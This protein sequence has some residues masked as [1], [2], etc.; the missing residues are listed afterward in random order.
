[1]EQKP[2]PLGLVST[3]SK[4][5]PVLNWIYVDTNTLE[6]RYGNKTQSLPHIYAPWDWTEGQE[7]LTLD[8]WEGFVALEEEVGSGNWILGYD[9]DD[10]LLRNVRGDRTVLECS[11]RRQL[12]N[13]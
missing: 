10:D 2:Q 8:G 6:L 7:A 5:P 11:L 4:E 13:V 1:M 9:R 3:I 12:L